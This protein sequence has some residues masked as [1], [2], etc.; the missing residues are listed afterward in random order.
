[1]INYESD[2]CYICE[3]IAV[4]YHE[5]LMG[6]KYK[7]LSLKYGLS[8]PVC[9]KCHKKMHDFAEFN[10]KYQKIMQTDFEKKYSHSEFMKVFGRNY[11]D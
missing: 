7:K 2:Y 8:I 4:E 1:M 6:N 11:L 5:P 10:K 3:G 9:R